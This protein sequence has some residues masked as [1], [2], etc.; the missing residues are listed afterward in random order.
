MINKSDVLTLEDGKKYTVIDIFDENNTKYIYL[1][2]INKR[3]NMIFGKVE[4]EDIVI[5]TDPNELKKVVSK[6]KQ[7][8]DDLLK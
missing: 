6:I 1:I 3:T 5:I 2:D 8:F 4:G 7:N